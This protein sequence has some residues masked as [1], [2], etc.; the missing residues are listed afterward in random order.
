[1]T[2]RHT[3][4]CLLGGMALT[5]DEALGTLR[6]LL[7][8]LEDGVSEDVFDRACRALAVLELA[9]D[10]LEQLSERKHAAH[11]DRC[12]DESEEHETPAEGRN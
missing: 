10:S 1:M 5:V 9:G 12:C 8:A 7:D 11:P 2:P 4:A 3:P 6:Q